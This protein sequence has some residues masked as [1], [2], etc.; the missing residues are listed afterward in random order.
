MFD[1]RWT[2]TADF[3]NY[4]FEEANPGQPLGVSVQPFLAV[5]NG[6]DYEV[7][8]LGDTVTFVSPT[9]FISTPFGGSNTFTLGAATT[10]YAAFFWQGDFGVNRSP[11]GFDNVG[12]TFIRFGGANSPVLGG[13]ISGGAEG[14]FSRTY[15]FSVTIKAVPEP[16]TLAL[17]GV[18]SPGLIGLLRRRRARG[19]CR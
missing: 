14:T 2:H 7:I 6:S 8:A 5:A 9:A 12:S 17:V 3:F 13:N 15:D 19:A 4:Q 1:M 11:I 10:V 18:G 16:S